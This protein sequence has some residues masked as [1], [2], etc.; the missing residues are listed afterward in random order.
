MVQYCFLGCIVGC[1]FRE[2][3]REI[4]WP[5]DGVGPSVVIADSS[6]RNA[7]TKI[8]SL[9]SRD[10]VEKRHIRVSMLILT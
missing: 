4:G 5:T 7:V 1:P 9:L 8:M 2:M 6:R 10:L 3:T